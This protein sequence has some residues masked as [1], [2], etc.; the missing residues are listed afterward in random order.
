MNNPFREVS[1]I[2]LWCLTHKRVLRN[3]GSE[4]IF[5]PTYGIWPDD[6]LKARQD[7]HGWLEFDLSEFT[8]PA[9]KT[10]NQDWTVQTNEHIHDS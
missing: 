7:R 1:K 9:S 4:R 8:C 10:C 5:T 3:C 6:S 2:R